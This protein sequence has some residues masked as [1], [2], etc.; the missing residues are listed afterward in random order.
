MD[1]RVTVQEL[2][3]RLSRL[4]QEI[5]SIRHTLDTLPISAEAHLSPLISANKTSLLTQMQNLFQ[6]FAIDGSAI[7]PEALQTQMA[8]ADLDQN[9]LS[10]SLILARDEFGSSRQ[11][12]R[13]DHL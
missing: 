3:S 12:R 8:Q 7:G 5:A 6:Q 9:E 13:A 1:Y 11:A 4:E 10:H 2:T